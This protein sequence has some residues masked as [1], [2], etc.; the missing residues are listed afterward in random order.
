MNLQQ[1]DDDLK[2]AMLAKD[3]D[4]TTLLR[5]LK[6]S[7]KNEQIAQKTDELKEEQL[8]AVIRKETKK[9][10]EAAE[11]FSK[12]GQQER[13]AVELAE[14][15]VLQAYL[16]KQMDE[17]EVQTIV[18]ETVK[19]LGAEDVKQMGQVMKA[20]QAKTAG[21]ADGSQVAKLVREALS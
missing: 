21:R 8:I 10:T 16:P 18:D 4:K 1:I 2:Q 13:A 14:K 19:E 12:G 15:E 20:V 7:I 3:S 9:R 11:M 6:A 5:G 17:S